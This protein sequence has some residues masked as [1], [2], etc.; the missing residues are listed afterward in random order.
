MAF[1]VFVAMCNV[2]LMC[3]C[4]WLWGI[5]HVV[6][7]CEALGSGADAT[8]VGHCRALSRALSSCR[9][10]RL[11]GF[12]YDSLTLLDRTRAWFLS[13]LVEK[14]CRA[15]SGMSGC[16]A[17]GLSGLSG[18]CQVPVGSCCRAVEPGLK[19]R[20]HTCSRTAVLAGEAGPPSPAVR[21]GPI[22]GMGR[23]VRRCLAHPLT[24]S[25]SVALDD[26][27]GNRP[28]SACTFFAR[29]VQADKVNSARDSDHEDMRIRRA[30]A[31]IDD[32]GAHLPGLMEMFERALRAG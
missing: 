5:L 29:P 21:P 13:S 26:A 24:G 15:L 14:W 25:A 23:A 17:V 7:L 22:H 16:R 27:D 19:V 9:A 11:S 8:T 12:L 6:L 3:Y 31:G 4:V 1:S 30:H 18:S 2:L 10:V 32:R 28:T 20:E